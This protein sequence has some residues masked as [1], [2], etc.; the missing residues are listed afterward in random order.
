MRLTALLVAL[1]RVD[2]A[3]G[4]AE[5]SSLPPQGSGC[6]VVAL[7]S[8][9]ATG[10]VAPE[11]VPAA[12]APGT[13]R[14]QALAFVKLGYGDELG[15]EFRS[16]N[17]RTE[18]LNFDVAKDAVTLV[19]QYN[20][21]AGN[22]V[23]EALEQLRGDMMYYEF[24]REDSPVLYVHLAHWTSQQERACPE[25]HCR[26]GSW[27][28]KDDARKLEAHEHAALVQRVHEAFRGAAADTI[29]PVLDNDHVLRVWW[30]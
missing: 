26:Q 19:K 9:A 23:A 13:R 30:D 24:G 8:P 16:L 10:P 4:C 12:A 20:G 17:F 3:G 6:P 11:A 22:K 18:A 25:D 21:F 27:G 15:G 14:D 2:L 7:A 28:D 1:A 5:E 29:D